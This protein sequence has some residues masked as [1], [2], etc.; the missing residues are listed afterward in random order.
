LT[1]MHIVPPNSTANTSTDNA[2]KKHR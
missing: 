2:V 1:V